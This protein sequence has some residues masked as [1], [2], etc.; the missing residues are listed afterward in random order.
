MAINPSSFHKLNVI[1][2]CAIWNLLS[3][4]LLYITANQAGCLFC[5]TY[6]VYYECL[7]KPRKNPKQV[8]RE[9]QNRFRQE[10]ER[11][12]FKYYHLTIEDLQDIDVI[13]ERKKVDKGELAS[14]A[15]A[16]KTRQALL[17]D[18]QGARKLA[19]RVI[20]SQMV[21]TT[22]H[23]LGW[24]LFI[25]YLND[26]DLQ[27]IIKEHKEVERPLEKYFLEVYHMVLNYRLKGINTIQ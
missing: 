3:S 22:P 8:E 10:Y 6:F 14:I 20:T 4:N 23:L 9:L 24:L 16:K 18:D 27:K 19:G 5:C 15:F 1:D 21:Q 25:S 17:T 26:N 12:K 13:H 11:G 2:T 7:Q